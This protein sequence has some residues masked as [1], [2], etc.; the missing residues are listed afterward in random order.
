MVRLE[1]PDWEIT[2]TTLFCEDVDDEVTLMV[3][4]DGTSKCT[5][6]HK[7][8]SSDKETSRVM[9]KKSRRLGRLPVCRGDNCPKTKQY[10]D[11]IFGNSTVKR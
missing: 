10:R 4:A 8:S 9:K 1:K 2:V 3:Y 7:Y 11:S 6:R 5:G